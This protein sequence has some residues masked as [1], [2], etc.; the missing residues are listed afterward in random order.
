[1]TNKPHVRKLYAALEVLFH[2]TNF[3]EGSFS[4][5]IN[6]GAAS[7]L[8]KAG[9]CDHESVDLGLFD[10]LVYFE[11]LAALV[12]SLFTEEAFETRKLQ[13]YR[14]RTQFCPHC[15]KTLEDMLSIV[16]HAMEQANKI[17]NVFIYGDAVE[18]STWMNARHVGEVLEQ[19]NKLD[20]RIRRSF[21]ELKTWFGPIEGDP[22]WHLS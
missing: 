16:S 18:Q 17:L 10:S 19:I 9:L 11:R 2:R 4:S 5:W 3:V 13:G 15:M 22:E 21:I 1:M 6:D 7:K 12:H 8:V 20:R 14:D